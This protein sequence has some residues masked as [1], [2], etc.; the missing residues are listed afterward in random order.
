MCI[1]IEIVVAITDTVQC[2]A[3]VIQYSRST[4]IEIAPGNSYI[5]L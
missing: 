3:S 2:N 5:I 1:I 4:Q